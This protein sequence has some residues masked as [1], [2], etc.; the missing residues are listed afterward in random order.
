MVRVVITVLS[1]RDCS[2]VE[3]SDPVEVLLLLWIHPLVVVVSSDPKHPD[4]ISSDSGR[5]FRASPRPEVGGSQWND[6]IMSAMGYFWES[7]MVSVVAAAPCAGA[8]EPT[9]SL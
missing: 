5:M 3:N 8:T 7:L 2:P 6:G 9:M 1:S 4:Y